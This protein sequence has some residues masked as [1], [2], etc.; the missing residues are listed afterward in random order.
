MAAAREQ[1]DQISKRSAAAEFISVHAG[2]QHI[3]CGIALMAFNRVIF[4]PKR[5]KKVQGDSP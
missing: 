4:C 5:S 3:F 2:N 1:Q